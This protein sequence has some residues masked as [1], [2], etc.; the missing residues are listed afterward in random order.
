[1]VEHRDANVL[2]DAWELATRIRNAIMLVRGRPSDSLP[3][4]PRDLAAVARVCGY[5]PGESSRFSDDYRR[6]ARRA[7]VVVDRLFWDE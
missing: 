6:R 5:P 2:R 4:D 1:M 7:R 3:R